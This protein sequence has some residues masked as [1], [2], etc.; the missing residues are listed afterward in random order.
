MTNTYTASFISRIRKSSTPFFRI[1]TLQASSE[2]DFLNQ[3]YD[4]YGKGCWEFRVTS[5][6]CIA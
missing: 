2:A 1:I 3:I 4:T 5:C 6:K